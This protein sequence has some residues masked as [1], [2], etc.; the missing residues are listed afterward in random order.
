MKK[1]TFLLTLLFPVILCKK[2]GKEECEFDEEIWQRHSLRI[3]TSI[4]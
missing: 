4:F 3:G 1:L 2:E